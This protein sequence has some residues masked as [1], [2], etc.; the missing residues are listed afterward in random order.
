MSNSIHITILGDEICITVV[1]H[2]LKEGF[3]DDIKINM[4]SLLS[5]KV[6]GYYSG[7]EMYK[8]H[9]LD[10][11]KIIIS[12][13]VSPGYTC[14]LRRYSAIHPIKIKF[15]SFLSLLFCKFFF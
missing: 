11:F 15:D 9:V 10:N 8:N 7:L 2:F 12:V 6:I 13:P 1:L 14:F 4:Y 5:G 3:S